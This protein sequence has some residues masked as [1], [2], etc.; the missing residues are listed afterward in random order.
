MENKVPFPFDFI[1]DL[2][3]SELYN[4]DLLFSSLVTSKSLRKMDEVPSVLE[5]KPIHILTPNMLFGLIIKK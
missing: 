2:A 1:N 5:Q 4:Q 3:V